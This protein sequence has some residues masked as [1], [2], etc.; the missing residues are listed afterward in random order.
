[1][2]IQTRVSKQ[3][4]AETEPIVYTESYIKSKTIERVTL[5]AI[6]TLHVKSPTFHGSTHWMTYL[7]QF[8]AA[9]CGNNWPKKTRQFRSFSL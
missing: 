8:K 5:P 3:T 1:M 2:K 7:R 6:G 4:V 9:A